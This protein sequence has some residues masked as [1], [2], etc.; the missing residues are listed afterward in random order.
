MIRIQIL[1]K[2]ERDNL[3][4]IEDIRTAESEKLKNLINTEKAGW[5]D[6]A[7]TRTDN[8]RQAKTYK[9]KIFIKNFNRRNVLIAN[10]NLK[11]KT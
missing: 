2:A 5:F 11:I 8:F 1:S 4:N 9:L 6:R 3:Q 7:K 10:K